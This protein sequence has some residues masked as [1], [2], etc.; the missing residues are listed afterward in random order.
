MPPKESRATPFEDREDRDPDFIYDEDWIVLKMASDKTK[1]VQVRKD[2]VITMGKFGS[3]SANH[4]I[5]KLFDIPFEVYGDNEARPIPKYNYLDAFDI[6]TEESANNKDLV[7]TKTAQ[8]LTQSEIEEMKADSLKGTV[9]SESVIKAIVENSATFE[10]KTEF[11]KAKYIK[12]K[13]K[14]YSKIFT[15]QRPTARSLTDHFF[16]TDP[17]RIRDIRVDTLSQILT[18]GNVRAKSKLLVVDEMSGLLTA[19]LMERQQGFGEILHLHDHDDPNLN[20]LRY[21]NFPPATMETLST[22]PWKRVEAKEDEDYSKMNFIGSAKESALQKYERVKKRM[23]TYA[24][25]RA[26]L[27]EGNFDGLFI[28]TMFNV[29]EVI[30]ELGKYLGGSRPLV[31]YSPYK[32][33]LVESYLHLRS[34][35]EFVNASITESWIREYQVPVQ[36]SGT[37]PAMR[38]SSSGGYLLT[39]LR[40]IDNGETWSTS[41]ARAGK[42]GQAKGGKRQRREQKAAAATSSP[43]AAASAPASGQSSAPEQ[44]SEQP[45]DASASEQPSAGPSSPTPMTID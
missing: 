38:M 33:L 19:A 44:P 31:V 29:K 3:F 30:D 27:N 21:M 14:K 7:D 43:A 20:M 40:V 17:I 1:V 25:I 6:E 9:H 26:E 35:R 39:A 4:I 34:S 13:S 5:G 15:P 2:S 22:F 8:K 12:R 16:R 18:A 23:D 32:E 24:A 11:S 36:A 41:F 37:H 42:K 10:G 28:S 45:S